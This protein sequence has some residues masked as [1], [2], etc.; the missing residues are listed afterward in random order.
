M[1][2][3]SPDLVAEREDLEFILKSSV[4]GLISDSKRLTT[5]SSAVSETTHEA[6]GTGHKL[7]VEPSVFNMGVLLPPSL[8]FLNRL[9]EVVPPAADVVTTALTSFLDEF[10]ANVFVPQLDETLADLCAQ[11]MIESDAFQEDPHWASYAQKP[12]FKVLL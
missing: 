4:P 7:L 2:S 3:K 1:D 8:T 12:I 9:R 5:I 6:S 10:L 11:T